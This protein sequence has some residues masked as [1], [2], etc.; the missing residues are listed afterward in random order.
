MPKITLRGHI[1]VPAENQ[2][3]VQRSTWG[4]ITANVQRGYDVTEASDDL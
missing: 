2:E 3:R 1:V 4:K